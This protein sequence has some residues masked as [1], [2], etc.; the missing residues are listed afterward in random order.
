MLQV[1]NDLVL[2]GTHHGE[3]YCWSGITGIVVAVFD[4]HLGAVTSLNWWCNRILTSSR[5]VYCSDGILH[6]NLPSAEN[7]ESFLFLYD[8]AKFLIFFLITAFEIT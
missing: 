7:F 8:A 4:V 1:V 3:L 5:Y 6:I 2:G